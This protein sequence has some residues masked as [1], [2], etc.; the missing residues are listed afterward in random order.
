M[1][2]SKNQI[3]VIL[4]FMT[5]SAK[6]KSEGVPLSVAHRGLVEIW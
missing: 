4:L 3:R 5:V 1:K 2:L 6:W